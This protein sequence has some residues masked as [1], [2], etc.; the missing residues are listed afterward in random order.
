LEL[1]NQCRSLDFVHDQLVT[2][3]RF[4]VLNV[5]DNVTRECV[6]AIPDTST[7]GRRVLPALITERGKPSGILRDNGTEL[8]SEAVLA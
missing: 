1:P 7:S 3:K 2:G 5:V 6:T 8:T 4:R